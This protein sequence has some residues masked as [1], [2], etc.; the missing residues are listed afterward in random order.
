MHKI[1]E[2][3]TTCERGAHVCGKYSNIEYIYE[4]LDSIHLAQGGNEC[5]VFVNEVIKYRVSIKCLE[6]LQ[7]L[8]NFSSYK[9]D[10]SG[11]FRWA[12]L[13]FSFII[14]AYLNVT[15]FPARRRSHWPRGLRR[16]FAATRLLRLWVRIPPG[17]NGCLSVV[18]VVR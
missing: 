16:R 10:F 13:L 2:R 8:Q 14:F 11:R 6:F 15:V 4:G 7:G 1:E 12:I 5:W 17:R 3:G 18:C 9:T